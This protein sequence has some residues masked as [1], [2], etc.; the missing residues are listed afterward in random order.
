MTVTQTISELVAQWKRNIT[1]DCGVNKRHLKG[2][3]DRYWPKAVSTR[4]PNYLELLVNLI[5]C[6]V[7]KMETI[8]YE[9]SSFSWQRLYAINLL[10]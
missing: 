7:Q 5:A 8:K 3:D 1:S 6:S 9:A 2:L 4:R 10:P